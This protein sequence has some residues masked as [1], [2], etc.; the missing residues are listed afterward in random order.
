MLSPVEGISSGKEAGEDRL[1]AA[2][3][4]LRC[5]CV[6]TLAWPCHCLIAKFLQRIRIF[7]S[8]ILCPRPMA[9]GPLAASSHAISHKL[10]IFPACSPWFHVDNIHQGVEIRPLHKPL[11]YQLLTSSLKLLPSTNVMTCY[12]SNYRHKYYWII[13]IICKVWK[14]VYIRIRTIVT[15]TIIIMIIII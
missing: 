14:H 1:K 15:I 11:P 12:S 6:R 13:V 2:K 7:H 8:L 5:I 10:C 4:H 3:D 9:I